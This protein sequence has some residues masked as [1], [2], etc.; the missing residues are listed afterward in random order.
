MDDSRRSV[1]ESV[2]EYARG[3]IGGLLF[4]LP[5]LY[6][7][8]VWWTGFRA[9]GLRLIGG[10]LF[11]F[12]LLLL[13]NRFAGMRRE[14]TWLEVAIDST[15]ELGLGLVQSAAVLWLLGEL[16]SG[17]GLREAVGKIVVEALPIAI[18]V[19]VGTAQLGDSDDVGKSGEDSK[20]PF[21]REASLAICGAFL[22]AGNIAPTDE[23]VQIALH[24]GSFRLVLL[25]AASML[26]AYAIMHHTG[27][28]G[29]RPL[30]DNR[31]I[32]VVVTYAIAIL[33]AAVT[34][35]FFGRFAH[36]GAQ[37]NVAQT[38]TLAFPAALGASAGRI[39]LQPT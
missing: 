27:F 32:G 39:L 31:A 16:R 28:R 15:E 23:V 38:V 14:S 12:F 8:E 6:T 26:T 13:Y 10:L 9:S 11:T 30:H 29:A 25:A 7:M 5:L 19:S 33:S 24:A 34:L 20:G 21:V 1:A 22:F 35:W 36:T 3:V 4:S 18:G 2:R 17:I 37:M